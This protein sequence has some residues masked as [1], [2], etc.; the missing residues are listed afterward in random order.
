MSLPMVPMLLITNLWLVS[1]SHLRVPDVLRVRQVS[2][3]P[4]I[5]ASQHGFVERNLT[6]LLFHMN[7]RKF[8]E[9]VLLSRLGMVHHVTDEGTS[10]MD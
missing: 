2:L 9:L 5:D 10:G 6:F 4:K 8:S 7:D 1:A 3:L